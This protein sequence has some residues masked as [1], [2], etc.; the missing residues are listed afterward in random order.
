RFQELSMRYRVEEY[1]WMKVFG[2]TSIDLELVANN[3]FTIDKVKFF[4]PEQ[5]SYNG[6]AYPIPM[7]FTFQLYLNF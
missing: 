2:L 5:A 4:D 7:T 1:D 3:L 6:G